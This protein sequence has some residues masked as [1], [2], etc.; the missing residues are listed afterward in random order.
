MKRVI[1]PIS[2]QREETFYLEDT[3]LKIHSLGLMSEG[4]MMNREYSGTTKSEVPYREHHITPSRF[5]KK[6][7][8]EKDSY[9]T[10][11]DE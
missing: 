1:I 11:A 7:V 5:L 9:Q 8:G 3:D 10:L 4:M 6:N 2:Q